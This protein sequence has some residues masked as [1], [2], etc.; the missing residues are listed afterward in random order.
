MD[1]FLN[2]PSWT[3]FF[4][5]NGV[6]FGVFILLIFS[7]AKNFGDRYDRGISGLG[8]V[9]L[10]IF[11]IFGGIFGFFYNTYSFY[12][13]MKSGIHDRNYSWWMLAG[14]YILAW[15]GVFR[16]RYSCKD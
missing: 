7:L 11:A 12:L 13:M 3:N 15:T 10:W 4:L 1:A 8:I 6:V 14:A 9:V 16:V 5:A 2:N